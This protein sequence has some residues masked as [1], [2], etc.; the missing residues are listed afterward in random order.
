MRQTI[1]FR[2]PVSE[3][4]NSEYLE[5]RSQEGWRLAAIEWLREVEVASQAP[6][7][8]QTEVPYGLRVAPDGW[9]LEEESSEIAVLTEI[10]EMLL[11][12][13]SLSGVADG[14][15]RHG[16]LMR[17]GAQWDPVSIFNLLPR[18]VEI[19][20][21]IFSADDWTV[22]RQRLYKLVPGSNIE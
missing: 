7:P 8:P 19:G 20:P 13:Y 4:P 5:R 10:M 21:R 3:F 9:H 15:N 18:I 2:E 17:D 12:D 14:L 11:R 16:F 22:R 1:R 6:L